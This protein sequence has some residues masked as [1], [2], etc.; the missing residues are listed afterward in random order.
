MGRQRARVGHR[1]ARRR[2]GTSTRCRQ[3]HS[4]RPLVRREVPGRRPRRDA[5]SGTASDGSA[6]HDAPASEVLMPP[7]ATRTWSVSGH[8]TVARRHGPGAPGDD[9]LHRQRGDV[10]RGALRGLLQRPGDA[11]GLPAGGLRA[12]PQ[13][14]PHRGRG[15]DHPALQLAH[16]AVGHEPH[17]QGRPH[18]PQ[19]GRR[20]DARAGRHLPGH[21]AVRL[22]RAH[23]GRALQHRQRHLRDA[24]LHDDR[25]PRRPRAGRRRRASRS[26]C[27]GA[28]PGSSRAVTT[29]P[30]KRST[31]TGTSWTSS[32]SS[33]SSSSTSSSRETAA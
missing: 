24:L 12:R 3:V 32:G 6:R 17:P 31:T 1:R 22:L 18:G 16:H 10:L 4:E 25:L 26:S 27:R 30:W 11:A 7:R 13:P 23:H 2:P 15:H 14:H 5:P 33:S 28:W 29:S 8:D 20:R 21:P 19:P 9:A